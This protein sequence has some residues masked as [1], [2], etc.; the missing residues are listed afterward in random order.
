M[1]VLGWLISL[2]SEVPPYTKVGRSISGFES[3]DFFIN[4]KF[5]SI[6]TPKLITQLF[7]FEFRAQNFFEQIKCF[8]VGLGS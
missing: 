5:Q 8:R 3:G 1:A 7:E 6:I 4:P 2:D